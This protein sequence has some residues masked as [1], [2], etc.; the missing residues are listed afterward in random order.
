MTPNVTPYATSKAPRTDFDTALPDGR[1]F[2]ARLEA[3]RAT[4]GTAPGEV[5]SR[6]LDER[7]VGNAV[8]LATFVETDQIFGFGWWGSFWIPMFQFDVHDFPIT[9]AAQRVR[10]ALPALWSGWTVASW[11]A[12]PSAELQGCTPADRLDS[13]LKALLRLA[14]S[15]APCDDGGPAVVPGRRPHAA[16]THV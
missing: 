6:L 9:G 15:L 8:S 16:V 4:G 13:D 5:A 3:F 1:G 2:I 12:T 10:A 7:Q 11:F 14:N